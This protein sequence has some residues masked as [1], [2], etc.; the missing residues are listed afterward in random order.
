MNKK[1]HKTD[2]RTVDG[3]TVALIDS[4]IAISRVLRERFKSYHKDFEKRYQRDI[5]P[6]HL[7]PESV[8]EALKD[9]HS[10]EN[11]L[12][13]IQAGPFNKF[14]LNADDIEIQSQ[15]HQAAELLKYKN[16]L[17]PKQQQSSPTTILNKY[18]DAEDF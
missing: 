3:N 10:D 6:N 5:E 8:Y 18:P 9:L 12:F 4:I 1:A 15:I 2:C 7:Y 13:V 11:V 17:N 14:I 16:A